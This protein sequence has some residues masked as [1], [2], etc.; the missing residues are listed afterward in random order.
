MFVSTGIAT[1]P[2]KTLAFFQNKIEAMPVVVGEGSDRIYSM[3]NG[4]G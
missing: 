1:G 3:V 2:R 4:D